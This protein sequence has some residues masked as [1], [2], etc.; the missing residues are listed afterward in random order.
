MDGLTLE[1]RTAL[2]TGGAG[3]LGR[4]ICRDLAGLGARV[5]VADLDEQGAQEVAAGLDDALVLGVDLER[6][7][8]VDAFVQRVR[9]EAGTVD[10]LVNN[11]GWDKIEPFVRSEPATWDR[12][13]AINLRAPI[14]L[15]HALLPDMLEQGWG[16]L[17]FVA[18]D[19]ARVGSSGEAVY[20]A[21][22]SGLVGLAKTLARESARKGVTSNAVCPGPSDT[23]LL[24]GLAAENPKL[25]AAL[26]KAIP[27]GRLGTGADVAGIVAFLASDRAQYMTGQTI[28]VSGGLTM[29]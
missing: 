13:I 18:S 27:V 5:I 2:V 10:V 17:I 15:T 9:E 19:A 11:A 16:R 14:Q 3:G 21:C 26:E 29:A 25:V 20:S 4:E 6:P 7:E 28:S 23:P 22:K 1:G 12:L 24:Q 8:A